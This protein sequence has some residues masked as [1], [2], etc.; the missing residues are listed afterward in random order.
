MCQFL[1][2]SV[3]LCFSVV[4][5]LVIAALKQKTKKQK[6]KPL[7]NLMALND[8]H[9]LFLTHL[10]VSWAYGGYAELSGARS[11]FCGQLAD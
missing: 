3:G 2:F 1:R 8:D 4:Y 7:H 5:Q 6:N 9:G 11:C 10:W